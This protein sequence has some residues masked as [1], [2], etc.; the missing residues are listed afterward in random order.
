MLSILESI[1]LLIERAAV[2]KTAGPAVNMS[3]LKA[4]LQ[5]KKL[6]AATATGDAIKKARENRRMQSTK[7]SF[8]PT[9]DTRKARQ[10]V[11]NKPFT[12]G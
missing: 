3:A 4:N 5:K 12:F 8:D 2:Y 10:P 6:S 9:R 7:S 11:I 1:D